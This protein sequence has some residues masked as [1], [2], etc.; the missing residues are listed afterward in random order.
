MV[1][2]ELNG[3]IIFSTSK[4]EFEIIKETI[5]YGIKSRGEI[6][7][8]KSQIENMFNIK[9]EIAFFIYKLKR[10]KINNSITSNEFV[11][12][13]IKNILGNL[14]DIEKTFNGRSLTNN[15]SEEYKDGFLPYDFQKEHADFSIDKKRSANFSSPGSGKTIIGL[16]SALKLFKSGKINNL[17]VFGPKSAAEAWTN[18]WKI[19]SNREDINIPNIGKLDLSDKQYS[20]YK[21]MKVKLTDDK[22]NIWFINYHTLANEDYVNR[23]LKDLDQSSIYTIFDE[24]HYLKNDLGSWHKA[25]KYFS[26]ASKYVTVLSGTPIPREK[27]ES[28]YL[29]SLLFPYIETNELYKGVF[30]EFDLNKELIMKFINNI[31]IRMSKSDL[32]KNNKLKELKEQKIYMDISDVEKELIKTIQSSQYNSLLNEDEIELMDKTLLLRRMQ[33][34]SYPPLLMKKLSSITKEIKKDSSDV[35]ENAIKTDIDSEIEDFISE[36]INKTK[37][38]EMIKKYDDGTKVPNRWKESLRIISNNPGERIIVWDIFRLSM[39]KYEQFLNKQ[40]DRKVFLINGSINKVEDRKYIIQKFKDTKGAILIASPATIAESA[41]FHR[42]CDIA[43]YLYKNYVG[44]HWMQS[45]DRIHRLVR[46]GETTNQKKI[47]DLV[48]TGDS[49]DEG[50]VTNLNKKEKQQMEIIGK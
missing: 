49:I 37:F 29:L 27:S 1:I 3:K 21:D 34:S 16:M 30:N 20:T 32:V 14:I 39:E 45:K 18:E 10:W 40:T 36:T 9:L 33:A 2:K 35:K 19:V 31:H 24:V 8:D 46:P 5:I 4:D 22:L 28:Y 50:I 38:Q 25:A 12:K 48:S 23:I 11:I 47:Y 13:N 15:M 42:E 26:V 41:S 44:S 7:Y 17:V 6:A 43:I